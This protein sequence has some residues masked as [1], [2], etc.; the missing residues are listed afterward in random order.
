MT[1]STSPTPVR[2]LRPIRPFAMVAVVLI[3]AVT[4]ASAVGSI[5][6]LGGW[7]WPETDG[8]DALNSAARLLLLYAAV[9][10]LA[11]I[12]FVCWLFRAR[13][14]AYA[15]S[16][17]V[18]HSYAAPFLVLG[19]FVPIV[20]LFVP[21]GIVDDVWATSR[22]GGLRPGT[23]LLQVRRPGL[24]WAWW[25]TWIGAGCADTL[26]A[27]LTAL[28]TEMDAEEEERA[29]EVASGL[30]AAAAVA[31]VLLAIAAGLL[32]IRIVL[33]I[34]RLQEAVRAAGGPAPSRH[35]TSYL[36]LVSLVVRDYDEAVGF[37]TG[38][39]GF[40]LLEDTEPE[41]G[42]RR[43]VVR[44]PGAEEAA[45]LLERAATPEQEARVGDRTGGGPGL[46]LYT[47]DFPR[48]YERMRSAGVVFEETPRR[49]PYGAVAVFHDL[50]GN[51]WG[52]LQPSSAE[53]V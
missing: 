38:V 13:S 48:D 46:F 25:L 26:A 50:Y 37:Y 40:E 32:A 16:P 41:D 45:L 47:D 18:A 29:A 9:H 3:A 17:G 15:I 44:P 19:W 28:G 11:G 6:H 20:N 5:L 21:K 23:N 24:V 12:A 52:L 8:R 2:S 49:E 34:T 4:V 7:S 51:R 39:L 22:P 1:S 36:G 30:G 42:R 27:V 10:L 33:V 43:V 53:G 31:G 14:N 35:R